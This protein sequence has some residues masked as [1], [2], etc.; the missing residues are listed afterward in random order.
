MSEEVGECKKKIDEMYDILK[1]RPIRPMGTPVRVRMV[2][3][4]CNAYKKDSGYYTQRTVPKGSTYAEMYSYPHPTPA[5]AVSHEES[6]EK[7]NKKY[8][9]VV[10]Y[11]DG[12]QAA[13]APQDQYA[14]RSVNQCGGRNYY[15]DVAPA[16]GTL[17]QMRNSDNVNGEAHNRARA[18]VK[19]NNGVLTQYTQRPEE[20]ESIWNQRG[21]FGTTEGWHQPGG[22]DGKTGKTTQNSYGGR[23]NPYKK[24]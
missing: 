7:E 24:A 6:C 14:S 12:K 16:A 2:G 10:T 19:F 8:N 22:T 11:F 9:K 5:D 4:D 1:N 21:D 23:K 18:S 13:G 3:A 17:Q 15:D 20:K